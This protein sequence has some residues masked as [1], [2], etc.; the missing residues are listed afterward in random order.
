[1]HCMACFVFLGLLLLFCVPLRPLGWYCIAH[2][3][4][5]ARFIVLGFF[6][7]ALVSDCSGFE[8]CLYKGFV[9]GFD[10]GLGNGF[11]F[12]SGFDNGFG[13]GFGN[14]F[15]DRFGNGLGDWF[16]N[17]VWY[18]FSTMALEDVFTKAL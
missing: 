7:C 15:G 2:C 1:V 13:S 11:S 5:M 3:V 18:V 14:G 12:G 16:F 17:A 8:R 4:S 6:Q 9:N 10:N